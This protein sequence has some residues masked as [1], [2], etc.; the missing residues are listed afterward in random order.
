MEIIKDKYGRTIR[1][2]LLNNREDA[3]NHPEKKCSYIH[4]KGV[5]K[6]TF[7]RFDAEPGSTRCIRHGAGN[8]LEGKPKGW[9]RFKTGAGSRYL[10]IALTGKMIQ[11][12]LG[13]Y[14]T[15]IEDQNLSEMYV[16]SLSDPEILDLTDEMALIDAR[17]KQLIKRATSGDVS[18]I[19]WNEMINLF[20]ELDTAF[21]NLDSEQV[22][23]TMRKWRKSVNKRREERDA[24]DEIF[25]RMESR[26]KL[27][28]ADRRRRESLS[29]LLTAEKAME[30]VT[31]LLDD[32]HDAIS[33]FATREQIT[34]DIAKQIYLAIAH[35]FTRRVGAADRNVLNAVSPGGHIVAGSRGLGGEEILDSRIE[36]TDSVDALP[37]GSLEGSVIEG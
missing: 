21:K 32:I 26:R 33:G 4:T 34:N 30:L 35:R 2:D 29:L 27:A 23:I 8:P 28:E 25:D 5:R 7:C 12:R 14:E 11:K 15:A 16:D 13:R 17:N 31:G 18:P 20:D 1:L 3:E 36:G 10:P 22:K 37:E 6:G 9:K 19:T 24:W